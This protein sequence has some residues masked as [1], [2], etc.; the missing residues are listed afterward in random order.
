[1]NEY[2]IKDYEMFSSAISTTANNVKILVDS[3]NT[4]QQEANKLKNPELFCGPLCDSAVQEWEII[5]SK[6]AD[7]INGFNK[8]SSYLSEVSA[9]YAAADA[10]TGK[11][12]GGDING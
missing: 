7:L 10:A 8:I 1:M 11:E 4:V 9:E 12:V 5:N 2:N 6:T 3:L